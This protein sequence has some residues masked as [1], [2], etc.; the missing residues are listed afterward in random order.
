MRFSLLDRQVDYVRLSVMVLNMFPSKMEYVSRKATQPEKRCR[1]VKKF[2]ILRCMW[3]CIQSS[4][5]QIS[6]ILFLYMSKMF[7]NI[8]QSG[9]KEHVYFCNRFAVIEL[10]GRLYKNT[11]C[12]WSLYSDINLLSLYYIIVLEKASTVRIFKNLHVFKLN[13]LCKIGQ[14]TTFKLHILST[15]LTER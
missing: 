10:Q 2:A 6:C 12:Y 4:F 11:H 8:I 3:D 13:C 15:I 1:P 14:S 9:E 5:F 7:Y